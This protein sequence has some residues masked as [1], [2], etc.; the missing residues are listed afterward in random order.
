M[1]LEKQSVYL[2]Y[3]LNQAYPKFLKSWPHDTFTKLLWAAQLFINVW[4]IIIPYQGRTQKF[5][6][7][8]FE[9]FKKQLV[10]KCS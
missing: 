3:I 1:L 10:P 4:N 9:F 2:S 5:L 7:G 8:R 6:K